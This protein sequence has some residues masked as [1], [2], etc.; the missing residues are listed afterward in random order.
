[1]VFNKLFI[2]MIHKGTYRAI[3]S[4]SRSLPLT[5]KI[6]LLCYSEFPCPFTSIVL[7]YAGV[8]DGV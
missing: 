5:F 4:P 3:R 8:C 6:A 7:K 1:M 2:I